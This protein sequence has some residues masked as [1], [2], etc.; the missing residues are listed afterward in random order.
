MKKRLFRTATFILAFILVT[1]TITPAFAMS[2]TEKPSDKVLRDSLE[3]EHGTMYLEETD[4]YRL[5]FNL[6]NNGK[7]DYSI[8]Y[9]NDP[10]VVYSGAYSSG[11]PRG[12]VDPNILS[13]H[14]MWSGLVDDLLNSEPTEVTDFGARTARSTVLT[15]AQALNYV[16]QWGPGWK[17]P[18]NSVLLDTYY[19]SK[20][21]QIYES[22][23]G[24][25]ERDNI[26]NYYIGD[27]LKSLVALFFG[28]NLSKIKNVVTNGY[29]LVKGYIAQAN[30]TLT[31]FTIDNTRTKMACISGQTYYWSG[32]DRM[33]CVYSGDKAT[34]AEVTYNLAYADYN[35][36][37]AYWGEK[38]IANYENSP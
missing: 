11:G 35:Y 19:G 2:H 36:D 23:D 22:V 5:V 37:T 21:V 18:V 4:T 10:H 13:S 32:W 1:M 14:K 30:G 27:T 29:N 31:Y 8:C 7:I 3:M 26:V 25:V 15:E 34:F 6:Y 33:Y 12:I 17:T 38:A 20:T 28:F 9:K 16:S 24:I